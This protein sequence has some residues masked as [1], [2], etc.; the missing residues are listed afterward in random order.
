MIAPGRFVF[1]IVPG[2]RWPDRS[3]RVGRWCD[4]LFCLGQVGFAYFFF[5]LEAILS[6]ALTCIVQSLRPSTAFLVQR[7][8]GRTFRHFAIL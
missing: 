4:I 7:P 3:V 2:K 1:G 8:L 6:A 5:G